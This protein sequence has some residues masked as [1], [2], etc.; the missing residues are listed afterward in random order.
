MSVSVEVIIAGSNLRFTF[1]LNVR[2]EVMRLP[3]QLPGH[4]A[5]SL[6]QVV[7]EPPQQHRVR[8]GLV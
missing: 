6:L 3:L 7:D 1:H 4:L 2:E 5:A 8:L